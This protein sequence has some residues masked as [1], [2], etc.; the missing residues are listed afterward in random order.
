MHS[1]KQK[2]SEAKGACKHLRCWRSDSCVR[3]VL[4][5]FDVFSNEAAKLAFVVGTCCALDISCDRHQTIR[6]LPSGRG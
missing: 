2:H 3:P 1:A 4:R 5:S 6:L